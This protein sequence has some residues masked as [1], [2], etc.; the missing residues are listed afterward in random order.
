MRVLSFLLFS[1]VLQFPLEAQII[2]S[3]DDIRVFNSIL[4]EAEKCNL[5]DSTLDKIV[6]YVGKQLLGTPYVGGVLDKPESENLVVNLNSLDCVTYIENTIALSIIVKENETQFDDFCRELGFIR[7]RNG[8]I[9]GYASRLHYFYDW[10]N[11]NQQKEILR[12]IT[13]AVGGKPFIKQINIM[14]VNRTK[15]PH[16]KEDSSLNI[17]KKVEEELSSMPKYYIPKEEMHL[18]QDRICDGDLIAFATTVEGLEVAHV[19]IAVHLDKK[20]HL[21]HAS[22]LN[23]KVE[24]SDVPLSEMLRNK[25]TYSGIIVS[26][27]IDKRF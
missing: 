4:S 2:Y 6:T 14:S 10:I 17:V 24:I 26:R 21:M 15:Y 7:Y 27:L 9:D 11:N 22:S 13:Q 25:S 12:N 20:L 1:I 19:G 3:Q 16:L 18:C 8:I 5:A 23:K